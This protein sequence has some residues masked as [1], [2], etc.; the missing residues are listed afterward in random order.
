IVLSAAGTSSFFSRWSSVTS[1]TKSRVN[2]DSA[3]TS[4]AGMARSSGRKIGTPTSESPVWRRTIAFQPPYTGTGSVVR[5]TP[6]PTRSSSLTTLPPPCQA[7]TL[8]KWGSSAA[9]EG[10]I[11]TVASTERSAPDR[12]SSSATVACRHGGDKPRDRSLQQQRLL[13]R[14]RH[15]DVAPAPLG[16]QADRA[17][18]EAGDRSGG[19]RR[20]LL[21]RSR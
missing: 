10:S 12:T 18:E 14:D 15:P 11:R 2:L 8:R 7:V 9:S 6:G 19:D 13:P 4:G 16:G 17:D 21:R 5:Y 20:A 3:G 1:R